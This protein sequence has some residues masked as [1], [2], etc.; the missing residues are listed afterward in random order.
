[1][2]QFFLVLKACSH[3]FCVH[4][5]RDVFSNKRIKNS[6]DAFFWAWF[7]PLVKRIMLCNCLCSSPSRDFASIIRNIWKFREN[8]YFTDHR[9][10]NTIYGFG[11]SV[12]VLKIH[13]CYWNT[14]KY[15]HSSIPIQAIARLLA[16]RREQC[17]D[18]NN[19]LQTVLKHFKL[20][21][22]TQI[23]R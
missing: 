11:D 21:I 20:Y 10:A 14:Q 7:L 6:Y 18:V 3:I 16:T 1:M 2:T 12:P 19:P 5:M 15:E 13:V 17:V 22:L 9:T 8:N 4:W 23:V